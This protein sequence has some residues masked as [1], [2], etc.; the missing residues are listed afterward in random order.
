L[1]WEAVDGAMAYELWR[2]ENNDSQYAG[3]LATINAP[4]TTCLDA[5]AKPATIYYYWVRSVGPAGQPS[6]FSAGAV[7]LRRVLMTITCLT[8]GVAG[9]GSQ[10]DPFLLDAAGTYLMGAQDQDGGDITAAITWTVIPAS[11]ASFGAWPLNQLHGIQPGAGLFR[12][13]ARLFFMPYTWL[14]DAYCQT[15]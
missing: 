14:G 7:G 5:S 6:P 9:S 2:G 11:A 10:F 4:T 12:I 1:N 15:P 8:G 3:L 13:Q